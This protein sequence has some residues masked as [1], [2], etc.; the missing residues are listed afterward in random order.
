MSTKEQVAAAARKRFK[1]KEIDL[2]DGVAV[3]VR[4]LSAKEHTVLY[5]KMWEKADGKFLTFDDKGEASPTGG[6]YK[7][8]EG[9]NVIR[10]WLMATMSP[11]DAVDDILVDDVP[12]SLKDE[13][14][15]EARRINGYD[16]A[17]I[18]KNS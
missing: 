4:E 2:G 12:E 10:E 11:A 18:A 3:S 5:D 9:V 14:F 17:A 1:V 16:T 8:K 15:A 6:Y 7:T 13:L